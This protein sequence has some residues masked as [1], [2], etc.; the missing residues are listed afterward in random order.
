MGSELKPLL[1]ATQLDL[2]QAQD[3]LVLSEVSLAQ[4]R[5]DVALADLELRRAAGT[6]P[7]R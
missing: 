1:Q 5:F 7:G 3:T 6:F 4:A 2:L